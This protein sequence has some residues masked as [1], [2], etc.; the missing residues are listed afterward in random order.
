[1]IKRL[2][3]SICFTFIYIA[4]FAQSGVAINRFVSYKIFRNSGLSV[5]VSDASSGKLIA[6]Y[7]PNLNLTPASTLKL[8]TTATALEMFGADY[9]FMTEVAFTGKVDENGVL[10]GD[11]YIVGHGDPT[12]GSVYSTQPRDSFF[13][14][15]F[16]ALHEK[17][18]R[19]INGK[20][21][22]DES[23]YSTELIPAKTP[24]EDMGN[25]YAA[26]VSALNYSDNTYKLT[27]KTGAVGTTP[28]IVSVDYNIQG[29]KFHNYLTAKA[30]DK[31]S[32]YLYGMPYCG[33]RYIYGTVPAYRN[34]FVIKGDVPDPAAFLVQELSTYLDDQGI[35]CMKGFTTSRKLKLLS[36]N[37]DHNLTPLCQYQSDKLSHIIQITNKK[38]YNFFAESMLRLIA[39]RV[40]IDASQPDGVAALRRYWADRHLDTNI[41]MYDGSGLSPAN[42][43]NS[44]FFVQ[45]LH[46]MATKSV[47]REAFFSSLAIAG[48]DGTLR[49]FLSGS[50]LSGKVLAKSGSFE[51]VISYCGVLPK[52]S[53]KYH[54]CVIVNAFTCQASEVKRAIEQLLTEL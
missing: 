43:V 28:E 39:S 15:V 27:F 11:L 17:G 2:T 49:S 22:G 9:R 45:L 51:G 47:N 19:R 35:S 53:S 50:S 1:M 31:D 33:D 5:S 46:Y 12:I 41:L 48:V 42:R 30:N 16:T 13:R 44:L 32:A 23:A 54:F 24:W 26:G 3:S 40:S 52:G 38:S 14:K 21:V 25:Y 20:I 6:S 8:I 7:C 37:V 36:Q 29:L 18:I 34:A 4:S 10:Q